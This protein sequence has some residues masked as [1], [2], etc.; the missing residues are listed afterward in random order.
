MYGTKEDDIKTFEKQLKN[1]KW[2]TPRW[3]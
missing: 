2:G 3:Q 1:V